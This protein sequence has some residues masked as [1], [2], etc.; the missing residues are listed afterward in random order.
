MEN[1]PNVSNIVCNRSGENGSEN[2]KIAL[3]VCVCVYALALA[4]VQDE[5]KG[6]GAHWETHAPA[7][8]AI[9]ANGRKRD[10]HAHCD[11]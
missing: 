11:K 3:T 10:M 4:L 7:N 6:E 2:H 1:I 5:S 8:E 9:A